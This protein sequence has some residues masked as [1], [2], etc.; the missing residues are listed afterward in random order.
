LGLVPTKF[1]TGTGHYGLTWGATFV[2][3]A[4]PVILFLSAAY[5]YNFGRAVDVAGSP[6]ID[7]GYV[8][9]G[10]SFEYN[11]G[12]IL[13]LQERFSVNF[14]LNQRIFG[15]ATQNGRRLPD[16]NINAIAFNIGA[17]YVVSPRFSLDFL[18]QIGMSQDAPDASL[19]VR[20]PTT[21]LF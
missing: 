15:R 19:L 16:S 2:K 21:F 12:F 11:I 8:K 4:D 17:T 9:I 6:P 13:A 18:V 20:I 3:S 14:A 7:F 10:N 1:P 5:Y